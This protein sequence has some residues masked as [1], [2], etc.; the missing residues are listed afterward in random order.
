MPADTVPEDDDTIPVPPIQITAFDR[1]A[2]GKL[3]LSNFGSMANPFLLILDNTGTIFFKRPMRGTCDDFKVQPNGLL[4]YFDSVSD[5]FYALDT[6]YAV[7]DSFACGNGY[8]T[9]A[10]DLR[11]LPDGHALLMSYDP[12]TVDMSALVAGGDPAARVTGLVVQELDEQKNV[13]FQ[14]RSWDHFNILDA[15]HVNFT[16]HAVDCVHGNALEVD[17]DGELLL[18]SRH[19]DEITKIDRETGDII[20][21][22]GGNNN[23]FTLL[24][25]STWFSHQHAIRLIDNGHYTLFDNGNFHTPAPYSRAA[26]Y[27]L[28]QKAKTATLVWQYRHTPDIFGSATGYVQRLYNGNTLINW[29]TTNPNITE[30]TADGKKV[31]ELSLPTGQFTYRAYKQ[32]WLAAPRTVSPAPARLVSLSA[33]QPNPFRDET[34]FVATLSRSGAISASV[35]DASGRAVHGVISQFRDS[36]RVYRLRVNLAGKPSGVYFFQVISEQGVESRRMVH[37]N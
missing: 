4:T 7:V 26:E 6:T 29:G 23:Q 14:W 5:K 28:D 31:L 3:F 34:E 24:G 9:D 37:L 8:T 16:A 12:E 15:T 22:W 10:H 35:Y 1:T 33:G 20:W 11:L 21:R 19:L 13:V 25:D 30:V 2:R 17:A 32:R 36:P 27:V 18:S